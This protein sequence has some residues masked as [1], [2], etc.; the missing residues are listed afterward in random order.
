MC[1]E[2]LCTLASNG[3]L[4]LTQIS[5]KVELDKSRL[6]EYLRLLKN[7]GLIEKQNLGENKIFYVVT[8]RGLKVLKV[9]SPIIREA[10]K[11]EMRNFE[12]ISSV[13][14]GAVNSG[15]KK[16][17]RPKRKWKLSDFIKIEIVKEEEEDIQKSI[18]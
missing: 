4:K 2:I 13:L 16:E 9:I 18:L 3:P 10:H 14:S 12:A 15:I 11:I 5:D 1:I 7:R 17:K 6:I 8:E